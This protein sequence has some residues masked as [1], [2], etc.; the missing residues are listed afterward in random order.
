MLFFAI[1]NR[2][3]VPTARWGAVCH[4]FLLIIM[5]LVICVPQAA[6]AQ[7]EQQEFVPSPFSEDNLALLD[8]H[9]GQQRLGDG[10]DAYVLNDQ[11]FLP[12]A[13][14]ALVLELNISATANS[15]RGWFISAENTFE[16]SSDKID[17]WKTQINGIDTKVET[18][19]IVTHEGNLYVESS[20][21][22]QWFGARLTL[23]F[24]DSILA[25]KT[26]RTLPFEKRLM[27]RSRRIGGWHIMEPSQNPILEQ[28]YQLVELPSVDL[29]LNHFTTR[30]DKQDIDAETRTH[31][32]VV[33]HGDLAWMNSELFATGNRDDGLLGANFRLDRFGQKNPQGPSLAVTQFSL[34]DVHAPSLPLAPGGSGRGVIISNEE[35][36]QSSSHDLVDI[37]GDYHPGWDAELYLNGII[38]GFIT[39][40]EDGHYLFP[41]VTLFFGKN[42]FLI[43]FY[44]PGGLEEHEERSIVV[45]ADPADV[46]KLK[47]K[48]SLSQPQRSVFTINDQFREPEHIDQAVFTAKYGIHP[49]L[50]IRTGLQQRRENGV[51]ANYMNI[52][53]Q[54]SF[55]NSTIIANATQD[56]EGDTDYQVDFHTLLSNVDI[57]LGYTGYDNNP[58][59]D[60]LLKNSSTMALRG[61]LFDHPFSANAKHHEYQDGFRDDVRIS[62]TGKI[63]EL[64]WSNS[65][66]YDHLDTETNTR[67]ILNGSLLF[68]QSIKPVSLRMALYY[69]LIPEKELSGAN[70][71]SSFLVDNNTKFNFDIDYNTDKHFTRYNL[72]LTW[73]LPYLRLTPTISYTSEGQFQGLFTISTSLDKRRSRSGNYYTMSSRHPS[74]RGAI[75]ARLF[76][77]QNLDG[78]Y[79]P[80]EPLLKNGRIR[81]VQARRRGSSNDLGEVWLDRI[82]P[83]Q[84]TDIEYEA[85]SLDEP[86]M[87][88]NGRPFAVVA[89]PGGIAAVNMP[90]VRTGEIDGIVSRWIDTNF[91]TPEGGVVV[92]LTSKNGELIDRQRSGSDGFFLF[93]NVRPGSYLL[94]VA[95]EQLIE[96]SDTTITISAA[97]EI[98]MDRQLKLKK[99]AAKKSLVSVPSQTEKTARK[100]PTTIKPLVQSEVRAEKSPAWALKVGS[101]INAEN[102]LALRNAL[103]S[104]G[105]ETYT[106]ML[107]VR[108]K[109]FTRV[110]VGPVIEKSKLLKDQSLIEKSFNLKTKI[111]AFIPAGT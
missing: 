108:N 105:L 75:R 14:I 4:H 67:E 43:K 35:L 88:Y 5:I 2:L 12:L 46:G 24:S 71:A 15:A 94:R 84:P 33:S 82:Y 53:L 6:M 109:R 95:D 110:Y 11:T 70:L 64:V 79:N 23:N 56:D 50:N 54:S 3:S 81:A 40:S 89:R 9:F 78:S 80:G 85:S 77:D 83:W 58:E 19:K 98:I 39:I 73:E 76:E 30:N 36:V 103:K 99:R 48:F 72:G 29:R 55:L 65:L 45:G 17:G 16:L 38:V 20:L 7:V 51:D 68:H 49:R 87:I 41:D 74:S 106:R 100:V 63:N 97:G 42:S 96:S 101:F 111:E 1:L 27:R 13:D 31:Y 8:I 26:F 86:G 22:E 102:V 18:S 92:Q 91:S 44:G 104:K 60:G 47:Y 62:V 59:D 69:R 107:V 52:G 61:S 28:P 32:S 57:H 25:L 10:V 21:I 90:F 66:D 93:Q 34:G 37:E